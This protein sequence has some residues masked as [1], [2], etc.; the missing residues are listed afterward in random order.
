MDYQISLNLILLV[1]EFFVLSFI[2]VHTVQL[3][4]HTKKLE[5]HMEKLDQHTNKL[6]KHILHIEK[7]LK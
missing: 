3:K 5:K 7:K 4:E 1:I 2:V 6:D